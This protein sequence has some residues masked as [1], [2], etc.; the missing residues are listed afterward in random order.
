MNGYIFAYVGLVGVI[1]QGGLIRKL[2]ERYEAGSL[3]AIGI[4]LTALGLGSI[5]YLKPTPLVIGLLVMTL[6]AAGNGLFQPTQST[7]LTQ[8]SRAQ[9]LDL[10]SV[11]G[12]Q[13]GFGALSRIVGPILAAVIWSETVDGTGVWSYHT[14]FRVAG[15]IAI[16]AFIIYRIQSKEGGIDHA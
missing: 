16:L 14:V 11:M 4:I 2:S 6:I 1:V 5:P 9:G 8:E 7:M 10:G 15:A 12:V 13:E 3:M